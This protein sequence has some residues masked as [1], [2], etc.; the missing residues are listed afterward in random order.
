MKNN[1]YTGY[2]KLKNR[3]IEDMLENYKVIGDYSDVRIKGCEYVR[4]LKFFDKK[5][6]VINT[7]EIL[8]ILTRFEDIGMGEFNQHVWYFKKDFEKREAHEFIK[9]YS[10]MNKIHSNIREKIYA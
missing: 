1:K 10:N 4:K 5:T 7:G 6:D 8:F 2:K 9:M 3:K